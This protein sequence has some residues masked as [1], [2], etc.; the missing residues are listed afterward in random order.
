MRLFGFASPRSLVDELAARATF[1]VSARSGSS[2]HAPTSALGTPSFVNAGAANINVAVIALSPRIS[3]NFI[4]SATIAYTVTAGNV[5]FNILPLTNTVVGTQFTLA[6]T[7][8]TAP[9]IVVGTATTGVAIVGGTTGT[10]IFSG[11]S[12]ATTPNVV[13][14]GGQSVA[15]GFPLTAAMGAATFVGFVLQAVTSA[16]STLAITSGQFT[17]SEVG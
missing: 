9:T 2:N 7:A 4:V 17:A 5:A 10:A 16:A 8:P 11:P 13:T 15:L 12:V 1:G 3:G 14:I 6:G